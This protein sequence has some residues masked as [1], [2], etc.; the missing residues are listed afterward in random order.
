MPVP[1]SLL[2]LAA[3]TGAALLSWLL[4][5]RCALCQHAGDAQVCQYCRARYFAAHPPRC[6]VCALRLPPGAAGPCGACLAAPPDF[7][8]AVAACDYA[9]PGDELV[10]QLKFG[11]ALAVAPWCAGM[12]RDAMQRAAAA[13]ALPDLLLPVPL[14]PARIG[15]R[16]YNQAL[17]IARPLARMLGVPVDARLAVRMRDTAP[18]MELPAAQRAA[19]VR[20]AFALAPHA[21]VRGRHLGIVD[22]VLTTGRTAGSLAA[23]LKRHGAAR[24]T[25]LVFART[26]QQ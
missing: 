22:D 4:P 25:V 20:G 23:M 18:Q 2:P 21:A 6:P 3:R 12:L 19:N 9:A 5:H 10:L 1:P 14:A 11:G 24:V 13:G 26:P 7:D 8:A 16:G 15:L 17:E